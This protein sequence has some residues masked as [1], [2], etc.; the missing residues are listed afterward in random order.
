M[1]DHLCTYLW[2]TKGVK[3]LYFLLEQESCVL[4][5]EISCPST[6]FLCPS[7]N[8]V[9]QYDLHIIVCALARNFE[10]KHDL[11]RSR[12]RLF[13]CCSTNYRAV[14]RSTSC[15]SIKFWLWL[16]TMYPCGQVFG[17]ASCIGKQWYCLVLSSDCQDNQG[18]PLRPGVWPLV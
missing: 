11:V 4:E 12:A 14:A 18:A 3:S 16:D 6:I 10:L 7:T 15:F 5:H 17:L 8:F 1:P 2:C 9:L 13:S